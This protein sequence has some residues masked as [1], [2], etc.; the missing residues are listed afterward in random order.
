MKNT[1]PFVLLVVFSLHVRKHVQIVLIAL[2]M[3]ALTAG[4]ASADVILNFLELPNEGGIHVTGTSI[5]GTT[6][7]PID[8][9]ISGEMFRVSAPN[10]NCGANLETNQIGTTTEFL[11]NILESPGGPLSDQIHVYRLGGAGSQV[12]DFIS[13]PAPFQTAGP[14]AMVTTLV[15]TGSLQSGLTYTSANGTPVTISFTSDL[16]VAAVP[17]PG[18]ISLLG[19]GLGV[20]AFWRR[21]SR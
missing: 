8:I 21:K 2:A 4:T 1:L 13:D 9:T 7:T 15:E 17:E 5:Q 3:I 10:C 6:P 16:D 12:I 11:V 14:G 19:L 20:L 18:T